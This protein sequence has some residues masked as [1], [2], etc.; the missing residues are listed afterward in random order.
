MSNKDLNIYQRLNSVMK[1]ITTVFKGSEVN[2]SAS[3]SYTAVSHDDVT[4]LIHKPFADAGIFVE[5]DTTEAKVTPFEVRKEY[6]GKE[7][8]N[9]NYLAEVKVKATFVNID[10]PDERFSVS[11]YAYALDT[12]DKA[13][14]KAE[15]MAVKY[16]FLK[17]LLLESTDDEE[18]RDYEKQAAKSVSKPVLV[19][20]KTNDKPAQ[21]NASRGSF[22]RNKPVEV[23]VVTTGTEQGDL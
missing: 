16:I 17:N 9:T 14:G 19:E 11:K 20:T 6:N 5:I 4:A 3:R 18:S 23:P 2:V 7:Q 10:K 1:N 12:S 15:S 13:V 8:V 22:R 21:E